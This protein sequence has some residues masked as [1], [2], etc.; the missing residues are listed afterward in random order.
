MEYSLHE[1]R[2]VYDQAL[3]EALAELGLDAR[4]VAAYEGW[5]VDASVLRNVLRRL[6][7]ICTHP[8]VGC[9]HISRAFRP[10]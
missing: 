5:A 10:S 2:K 9:N 7:G 6:R 8:Q 4:G 1:I 3:E